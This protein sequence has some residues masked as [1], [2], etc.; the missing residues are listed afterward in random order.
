V[1][2]AAWESGTS[3]AIDF[4]VVLPD[5]SL[6]WLHGRGEVSE[7]DGRV[8]KRMHG[9]NQDI[10]AFRLADT[11]R[12]TSEVRYRT[13]V[14]TS[15]EGIWS[16]D[17]HYRTTFVNGRMAEMLGHEPGEMLGQSLLGH[18]IEGG[19]QSAEPGDPWRREPQHDCRFRRGDGSDFWALVSLS[20]ESSGDGELAGGLATVTDITVRKQAEAAL[21]AAKDQATQASRLKS[22]FLANTSHEIRTPM[23]V[24]LGMNDLLLD[25]NL[26]E[27]QRRL[28]EAV[29]RASN[30]LLALI[31][32]ILDLSK[33]EAGKQE[34]VIVD[35]ELAR[36]VN[37]VVAMLADTGASKD[38]ELVCRCDPDVP[39]AVRGDVRRLRQ[40]LVNLVSNGLK[41]T[42]RGGVV[43]RVSRPSGE[44]V[45]FEVSDT[46]IGIAD[47]D[48][49]RLFRP[50]SQVDGSDT[51]RHGGTGLG[52]AISKQL[53]EAMGGTIDFISRPGS[54]STFCLDVPFRRPATV[55]PEETDCDLA[56]SLEREAFSSPA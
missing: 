49:W 23:T 24:I 6:R 15:Q 25:T 16:F 3:F 54:G 19:P 21:A 5:G 26:D 12:R 14:E 18:I 1:I 33:I 8:A 31:D 32:D 11:A 10:T 20:W 56:Q 36:L 22:Q 2:A 47:E 53:A 29:A 13:L 9:T 37:D 27:T 48:Q 50:F 55:L 7:W 44:V 39:A 42:D 30:S 41:F 43:V 52:L 40:I 38:L 35:F 4:R 28:A 51:R 46:G 17:A 34:L 45:R